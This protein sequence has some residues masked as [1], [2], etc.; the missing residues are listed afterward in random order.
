MWPMV[1]YAGLVAF[2]FGLGVYAIHSQ[3]SQLD[4]RYK[5]GVEIDYYC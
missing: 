2:R 4:H 3:E 1:A 5:A